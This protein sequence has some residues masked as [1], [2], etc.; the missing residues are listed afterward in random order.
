MLALVCLDPGFASIGYARLVIPSDAR[1]S[2]EM[3]GVFHTVK[4]DK[5]QKVLATEDNVSRAMKIAKFL[6]QL[7]TTGNGRVIGFCAEA[8]SFPRSASVAAKM[9][10][11][12]GAL[13][14]LSEAASIPILQT[15][16]QAVKRA[17]CGMASATK[18]EVQAAVEKLYPETLVQKRAIKKGDLEHC[19]DALAVGHVMLD[20][21]VVKMTRRAA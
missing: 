9:A 20:S 13:A 3:F 12:W 1:P 2:V 10:M 4:S 16:P 5:K 21:D 18:E 6:R 8:M 15:S 11:T 19:F 17:L 7:T 14:S